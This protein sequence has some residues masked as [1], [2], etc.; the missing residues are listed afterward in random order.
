MAGGLDGDRAAAHLK[1]F[2]ADRCYVRDV[3]GPTPS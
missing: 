1:Q 2:A 3:H